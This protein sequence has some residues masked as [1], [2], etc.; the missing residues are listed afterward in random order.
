MSVVRKKGIIEEAKQSPSKVINKKMC[1]KCHGVY[2]K[3]YF[4]R[5]KCIT[6]LKARAISAR[7]STAGNEDSEF[8]KI[9]GCFRDESTVT[10]LLED[11]LFRLISYEEFKMLK[12]EDKMYTTKKRTMIFMRSL[13]LVFKKFSKECE[14]N[15]EISFKDMFL[16]NNC[17]YL[18]II[19]EDRSSTKSTAVSLCNVIKKATKR[20][21]GLAI[22]DNNEQ[23]SDNCKK[24]MSGLEAIIPAVV[25]PIQ[26]MNNKRR[27]EILRQPKRLPSF[28]IMQKLKFYIETNMGKIIEAGVY[29]RG[30]YV[31]LRKLL[32][33]RLISFNG[34]RVSEPCAITKEE[35]KDAFDGKWID[36]VHVTKRCSDVQQKLLNKFYIAYVNAKNASKNVDLVIPKYLK[37]A[38]S[39]M[40]NPI[41]REYAGVNVDN[42]FVFATTRQS[43]DPVSGWHEVAKVVK[44]AFPNCTGEKITATIVRHYLSSLFA[45]LSKGEEVRN[46]FYTHLGHSP[47]VNKD[48]YQVPP[49]VNLLLNVGDF[50]DAVDTPHGEIQTSIW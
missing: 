45:E 12:N 15:K 11:H 7:L 39:I 43:Q 42:K 19:L 20:L 5:H 17:I 4:Y 8:K 1:T 46:I 30:D 16:P 10:H 49:A 38:L 29:S 50:L 24:V 6:N 14:V 31:E 9:L 40:I 21:Q 34:R 3:K 32:I 35:L 44:S 36:Q 37:P 25:R 48:I 23:L 27:N 33:T 13:A 28:E 2:A 18:K 47:D 22:I 41:I 26:K